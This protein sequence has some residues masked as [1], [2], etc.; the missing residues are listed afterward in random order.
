[1]VRPV[2]SALPMVPWCAV[3]THSSQA[4]GRRWMGPGRGLHSSGAVSRRPVPV[5]SSFKFSFSIA[6]VPPT[7]ALVR[8]LPTLRW[9][10]MA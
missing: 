3:V 8:E 9:H 4:C 6:Q 7:A 5:L 2:A 1:M 10:P